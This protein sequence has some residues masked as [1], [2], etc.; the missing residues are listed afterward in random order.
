MMMSLD[1]IMLGLKQALLGLKQAFFEVN[2]LHIDHCMYCESDLYV[3]RVI[4][5]K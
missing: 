5:G 1:E 3:S 4:Q 2:R